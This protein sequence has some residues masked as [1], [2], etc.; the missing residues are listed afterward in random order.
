LESELRLLFR[1]GQS[2][3][4]HEDVRLRIVGASAKE[5]PQSLFD[6]VESLLGQQGF[7]PSQVG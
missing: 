2:D 3:L 7:K 1:P 6:L 5:S 4:G